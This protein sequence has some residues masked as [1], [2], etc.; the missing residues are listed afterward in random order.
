MLESSLPA[1]P[2]ERSSLFSLPAELEEWREKEPIRRISI[3]GGRRQPWLVSS[4]ELARQVFGDERFSAHV[5]R[6]GFP[7]IR[8]DEPPRPPGF[9]SNLD[10]PRHDEIRK[11]MTGQFTFQ[12][13]EQLRPEIERLADAVMDEFVA[14]PR[15]ADLYRDF[16]LVLPSLVICGLLGVPY[17]EHERFQELSSRFFTTSATPDGAHA[18]IAGLREVIEPF[19]DER[20]EHP[21]SDLLTMLAGHVDDGQMTRDEALGL[22]LLMLSA[23]HDTTSKTLTL[24]T[25]AL[26]EHPEQ[27]EA[28]F[29]D[30]KVF[31][32]GLEEI[33]RYTSTIHVGMRR[34]ATEDVQVGDVLVRAGEG[35]VIA[36]HAAN[37]DA[38]K[39]ENANEFDVH[40]A[41]ARHHVG[42]GFGMH[43]CLGQRL[44]RMELTVGIP[45]IFKRLPGLRM[46]HSPDELDL[47]LTE[48]NWCVEELL[49]DWDA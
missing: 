9:L 18:A 6:E 2:I 27:R 1:L 3:W 10:N 30:P 21:S 15:P 5:A 14:G 23:G 11:M 13:I 47:M 28:M 35:V 4:F 24:A 7:G 40:R 39:F 25:I 17:S 45:L 41:N 20:R 33:L 8:V 26:L 29:A 49:V 36:L 31:A 22:S 19:L 32:N 12:R 37:F 43:Q 38:R 44:A 48:S 34:I 42:F 16:A 46:I